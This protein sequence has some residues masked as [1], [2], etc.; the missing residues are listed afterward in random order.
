MAKR[1]LTLAALVLLPVFLVPAKLVAR[2]TAR[3]A[4]LRMDHQAQLT[5]IMTERFTVSGA[6]LVKLFG[7]SRRESRMF[8]AQAGQLARDGVQM[9]M[10]VRIFLSTLTLAGALATA[11]FYGL[12]GNAVTL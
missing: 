11:V 7:N 10:T 12:G 2:R 8:E 6:M 3:L 5:E 9:A 1:Q 4:R